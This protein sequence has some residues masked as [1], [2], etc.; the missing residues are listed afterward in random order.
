[1]KDEKS[2]GVRALLAKTLRELDKAN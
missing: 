2:A 1:L